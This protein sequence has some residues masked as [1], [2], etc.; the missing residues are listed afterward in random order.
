MPYK[1]SGQ[2]P[3]AR[4]VLRLEVFTLQLKI[5][6]REGHQFNQSL[7]VLLTHGFPEVLI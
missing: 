3:S 7:G 6:K 1:A 2:I 5:V 4:V